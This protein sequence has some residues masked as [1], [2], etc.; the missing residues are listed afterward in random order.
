MIFQHLGSH[1]IK[2]IDFRR[3]KLMVF[4]LIPWWFPAEYCRDPSWDQYYPIIYVNDMEA[5]VSCRLILYA[6]DSALLGSGTSVSV[7]EE[8]LGHELTFLSEWLVDN[9]LSIHLGKTESILFVSK[10]KIRKQS[11]M[12]IICGDNEV[13]AKDNVK[14]LGVSLDQS[15][16]G[17]YIAESILKKVSHWHRRVYFVALDPSLSKG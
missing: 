3:L 1:H 8:T 12:K 10:K 14:Y 5:A 9:K 15:L 11:T 13:T 4:F 2:K 7:I 17:K 6:D 16:G